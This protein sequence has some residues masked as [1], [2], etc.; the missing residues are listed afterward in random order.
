MKTID[1]WI[2]GTPIAKARIRAFRKGRYIGVYTP[3]KSRSWEDFIKFQ[4]LGYKPEK[5]PEDPVI[6]FASFYLPRPKSL[7]KKIIHHTKRPDLDNLLKS[8][9]DALQGLF[10]KNDSQI[11]Q[12]TGSK[13]YNDRVGV[14]IELSYLNLDER[15]NG[16]L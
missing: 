13:V 4:S 10:F 2:E 6:I 1:F 5:L 15:E 9:L 11:I 12:L 8:V 16:S 3:D 14:Q 7:P